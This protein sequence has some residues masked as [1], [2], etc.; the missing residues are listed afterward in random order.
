MCL[1][2]PVLLNFG[3]VT[4]AI[5]FVG[6]HLPCF[7]EISACVL[8]VP[9][10]DAIGAEFVGHKSAHSGKHSR[11]PEEDIVRKRGKAL[12]KGAERGLPKVLRHSSNVL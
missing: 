9:F 1:P 6:N 12:L 8:A 4:V 11:I 7:L 2:L 5:L 10:L 3:T